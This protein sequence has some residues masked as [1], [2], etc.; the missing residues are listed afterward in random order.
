M[1][2]RWQ[3]QQPSPAPARARAVAPSF[4]ALLCPPP[5]PYRS[6]RPAPA[7]CGT[8]VLTGE[9][10][11]TKFNSPAD[12]LTNNFYLNV[13]AHVAR[14]SKN[15]LPGQACVTQP[16]FEALALKQVTELWTEFGDLTE[17]WCAKNRARARELSDKAT[18]GQA[19]QD[20]TDR[21]S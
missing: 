19:R 5:A 13:G 16:Q 3:Q 14:G 9:A 11:A 18:A 7:A 4:C 17:I 10:D 8:P 6:R 2:T 1:L 20:R 12:S 21:E 15:C